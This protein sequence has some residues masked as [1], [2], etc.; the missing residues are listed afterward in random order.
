LALAATPRL[1]QKRL[2]GTDPPTTASLVLDTA[3]D[4]L[5]PDD[6]AALETLPLDETEL[7]K[8]EIQQRE[9]VTHLPSHFP[10]ISLS[11]SCL[12]C[13]S[14]FSHFSLICLSFLSGGAEE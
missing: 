6:Y 4:W 12:T 14:Y 7:P 10:L 2:P 9:Q 5:S 13:L 3:D 1:A 11:F 8:L